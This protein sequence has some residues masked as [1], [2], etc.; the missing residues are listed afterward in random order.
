MSVTGSGLGPQGWQ[1]A[2]VLL[3]ISCSC[4]RL[5]TSSSGGSTLAGAYELGLFLAGS[6]LTVCWFY[7]MGRAS[8][9]IAKELK[10][11]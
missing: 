3:V 11:T 9:H 2:Q 8:R 4:S 7:A 6:A 1:H 10:Q 5:Q